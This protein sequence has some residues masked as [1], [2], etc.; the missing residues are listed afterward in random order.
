M[1]LFQLA[2]DC[3]MFY[4][5]ILL[6][7]IVLEMDCHVAKNFVSLLQI[8]LSTEETKVSNGQESEALNGFIRYHFNGCLQLD[9]FVRVGLS[10]QLQGLSQC[11]QYLTTELKFK[12]NYKVWCHDNVLIAKLLNHKC[13]ELP[14]F[15][16]FVSVL[17]LPSDL[18]GA[19][20][21]PFHFFFFQTYII[22]PVFQSFL[23]C[24]GFPFLYHYIRNKMLW[25]ET[26]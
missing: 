7:C 9:Y 23:I 17:I 26:Q 4:T 12:V 3:I 6:Y 8:F 2:R 20:L 21:G 24:P 13:I 14:L 11:F 16:C 19:F 15:L 1:L 10:G 25:Y 22:C 18:T 5:L